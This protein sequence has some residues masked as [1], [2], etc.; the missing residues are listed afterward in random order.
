VIKLKQAHQKALRATL[1]LTL[2]GAL[3]ACG[4][5]GTAA[6]KPVSNTPPPGETRNVTPESEADCRAALTAAF[7]NGDDKWFDPNQKTQRA[8][9]DVPDEALASCCE[10]HAATFGTEAYRDLGCCSTKWEGMHC[11]PWGPP[12]PPAMA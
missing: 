2:F 11:T 12:M 8:P 9:T 5:G 4:G 3:G 1:R 6:T 10:R 7:P